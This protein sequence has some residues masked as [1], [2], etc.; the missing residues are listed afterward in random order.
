MDP[1]EATLLILATIGSMVAAVG[2][3]F[4]DRR[5]SEVQLAAVQRK[6]DLVMAHLG[7][8]APEEAEVVR[9][10]ENGR[11]IDAVRAYRKQTGRGLL[12]SKQAVDRIAARLQDD[13]L[14][15]E[16]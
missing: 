14:K 13:R 10:L 15:N 9:H 1:F 5:I 12:E 3:W 7:I 2:A 16:F 4:Q 11:A 8:P 6:L